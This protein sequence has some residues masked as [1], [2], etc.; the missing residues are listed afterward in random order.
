MKTKTPLLFKPVLLVLLSAQ[1]LSIALCQDNDFQ[2][3]PTGDDEKRAVFFENCKS[4]FSYVADMTKSAT[5]R[6]GESMRECSSLCAAKLR[7]T[8]YRSYLRCFS[9]CDGFYG[10]ST[11]EDRMPFI[12]V[13]M[14]KTTE[15][16]AG[17][18]GNNCRDIVFPVPF[19]ATVNPLNIKVNT[20]LKYNKYI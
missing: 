10:A 3:Q 16:N 18:S 17:Y 19:P 5:K 6:N 4:S 15:V 20:I 13:N 2:Y 9:C 8:S 14:V 7:A 1:L 11:D 12:P